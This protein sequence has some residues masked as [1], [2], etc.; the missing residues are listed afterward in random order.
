MVSF[1][2]VGSAT[3][4]TAALR[5]CCQ[6]VRCGKKIACHNLCVRSSQRP[7]SPPEAKP[8]RLNFGKCAHTIVRRICRDL[9]R[10]HRSSE[11]TG[12]FIP[13]A[14][15]TVEDAAGTATPATT[16]MPRQR[17]RSIQFSVQ[18]GFCSGSICCA[19]TAAVRCREETSWSASLPRLVVVS[20]RVSVPD[21]AG[22]GA[23]WGT[24]FQIAVSRAA[25]FKSAKSRQAMKA[26]ELA[27]I[28]LIEQE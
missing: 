9:G 26:V 21:A 17:L 3:W 1:W 14:P 4:R 18:T 7:S 20:N 19:A 23:I 13:S 16:S 24:A 6:W 2:G 22:K 5:K 12:L 28:V 11:C 15:A 25:S 10:H 8:V 27:I